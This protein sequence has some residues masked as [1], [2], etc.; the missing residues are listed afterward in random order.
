VLCYPLTPNEKS[1]KGL[2]NY[3]TTN[4]IFALRK[5]LEGNHQELWSEWTKQHKMGLKEIQQKRSIA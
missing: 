5:H 2:I 1:K 4:G 3:R